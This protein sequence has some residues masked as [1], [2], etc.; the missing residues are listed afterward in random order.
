MFLM[1]T[2]VILQTHRLGTWEVSEDE[3]HGGKQG[4]AAK[5][6]RRASGASLC[7]Q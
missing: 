3:K 6:E 2:L 4:G 5:M 7:A 1:E